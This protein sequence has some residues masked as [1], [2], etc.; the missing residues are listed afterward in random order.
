MRH[1]GR[2]GSGKRARGGTGK[3]ADGERAEG[4]G[5]KGRGGLAAER[6]GFQV[7]GLADAVGNEVEGNHGEEDCKAGPKH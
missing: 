5:D 2:E 1:L 3:D 4:A 6:S 7:D